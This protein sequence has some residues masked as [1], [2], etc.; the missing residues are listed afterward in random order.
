MSS[1]LISSC[2]KLCWA[3]AFAYVVDV[4]SILGSGLSSLGGSDNAS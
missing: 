1:L 2:V 3:R 4:L